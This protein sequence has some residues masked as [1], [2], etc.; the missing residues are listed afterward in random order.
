MAIMIKDWL[1]KTDYITTYDDAIRL[2]TDCKKAK[3]ISTERD[4]LILNDNWRISHSHE[5]AK[6]PGYVAKAISKKYGMNVINGHT[7]IGS[8]YKYYELNKTTG[9]E[10]E[11]YSIDGGCCIDFK[12]VEYEIM[13]TTT[14]TKWANLFVVIED[15][16]PEIFTWQKP[17]I[18]KLNIDDN[19]VFRK[20]TI[21]QVW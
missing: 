9:Y 1:K 8:L 18:N 19:P 4:Y 5:Y 2:L 3:I 20:E 10:I 6:T 7:H 14:F 16:K 15:N 11:R 17:I 21:E 12:K 13:N